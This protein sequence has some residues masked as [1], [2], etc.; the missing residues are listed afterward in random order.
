MKLDPTGQNSD[1]LEL[2]LKQLAGITIESKRAFYDKEKQK[3]L[4]SLKAFHLI[5][6]LWFRKDE[7]EDDDN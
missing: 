2:A 5:E 1:Q 4:T 7:A 6:K 3:R